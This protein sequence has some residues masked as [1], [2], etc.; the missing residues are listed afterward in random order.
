MTTTATEAFSYPEFYSFP[1]FFTIQVSM[2]FLSTSND[3]E[4]AYFSNALL[5]CSAVTITNE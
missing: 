3:F 4:S 5:L 1:P 2:T